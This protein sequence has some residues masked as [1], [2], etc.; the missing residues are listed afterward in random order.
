MCV[1][2]WKRARARGGGVGGRGEGARVLRKVPVAS[3]EVCAHIVGVWVRARAGV[4]VGGGEWGWERMCVCATAWATGAPNMS[5]WGAD[6]L[7]RYM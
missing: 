4:Y 7:C 2:V 6:T 1:H 3:L 5:I